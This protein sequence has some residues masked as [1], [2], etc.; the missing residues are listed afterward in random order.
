MLS[1]WTKL[2]FSRILL[3][4]VKAPEKPYSLER[5]NLSLYRRRGICQTAS[6]SFNNMVNK[7]YNSGM[8]NLFH[9]HEQQM[10]WDKQCK[11]PPS[12]TE[13]LCNVSL[14][15]NWNIPLVTWALFANVYCKVKISVRYFT[16]FHSDNAHQKDVHEIGEHTYEKNICCFAFTLHLLSFFGLFYLTESGRAVWVLVLAEGHCDFCSSARHFTPTL[17]LSF[18]E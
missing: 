16:V 8:Q 11:W 10:F 1:W 17:L 3:A 9:L 7:I 12:S 4:V 18:H 14:W 2:K 6:E 13:L 5:E 15:S